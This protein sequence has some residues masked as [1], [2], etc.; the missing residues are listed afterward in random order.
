[1]WKAACKFNPII[2]KHGLTITVQKNKIREQVNSF[3]YL[4]NL[5][6]YEKEAG[7]DNKLNNYLKITGII[8]N[9]FRAQKTPMKTRKLHKKA[10]TWSLSIP[11][12]LNFEH[13][14]A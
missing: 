8:N 5:T 11:C 4:G 3:N 7:N 12:L 6:F 13:H 9:M 2:T 10:I 1:L 14:T